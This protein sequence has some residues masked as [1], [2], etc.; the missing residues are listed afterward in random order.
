MGNEVPTESTTADHVT[1]DA[2]GLSCPEPVIMTMEAMKSAGA[3]TSIEILVDTA[4]SRNNVML[5]TDNRSWQCEAT[6]DA[7]GTFHMMLK[8]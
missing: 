8:K 5:A 1:V 3:G 4:T 6:E 2:R 7:E